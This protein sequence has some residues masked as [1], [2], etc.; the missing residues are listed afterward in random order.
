MKFEIIHIP[1]DVSNIVNQNEQV[2]QSDKSTWRYGDIG[3]D[4][5]GSY[6]GW[7]DEW[8]LINTRVGWRGLI[9]R[10]FKQVSKNHYQHPEFPFIVVIKASHFE[11][12]TDS[13]EY[14]IGYVQNVT[15]I[16]QIHNSFISFISYG[17]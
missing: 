12:W 15:N 16:E 7:Y 1:E 11:L 6:Y 14:K 8:L 9:H 4:E 3:I 17:S 13:K 5:Y 10:G 2:N